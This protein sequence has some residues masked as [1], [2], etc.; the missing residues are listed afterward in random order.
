MSE[1][2]RNAHAE[3]KMKEEKVKKDK[4]ETES[5]AQ[6]QDPYCCTPGGGGG[7]PDTKP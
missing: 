6:T 4:H 5:D 2:S 3:T 7:G 1:T